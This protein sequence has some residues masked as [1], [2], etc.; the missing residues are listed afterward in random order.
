MRFYKVPVVGWLAGVV[1]LLALLALN[2]WRSLQVARRRLYINA[3]IESL[4]TGYQRARAQYEKKDRQRMTAINAKS[5]KKMSALLDRKRRN[6]I[7]AQRIETTAELANKV[8][9]GT[10]GK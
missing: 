3:R 10:D 1:V 9:G 5:A 4:R 2:L 8:F 6:I 7:A